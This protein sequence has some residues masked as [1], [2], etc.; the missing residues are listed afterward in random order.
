MV[1]KICLLI[2]GLVCVVINQCRN[3]K[4]DTVNILLSLGIEIPL[5]VLGLYSIIK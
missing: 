2:V 1:L 3:C 5:V 4:V